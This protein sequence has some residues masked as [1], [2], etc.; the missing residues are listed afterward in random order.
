MARGS[1][2]EPVEVNPASAIRAERVAITRA[3]PAP[4]RFPHFHDAAE[5]IWFAEVDGSLD[6]ED[7]TFVLGSGTA[8]FLPP[9]RRHD[10]AI[11]SGDHR[12][13]LVHLDPFLTA[14]LLERAAGPAAATCRVVRCEGALRERMAMLFDWLTEAAATDAPRAIVTGI[15]GLILTALILADA[16]AAPEPGDTIGAADRLRPAL[17]RIA[18]NPGQPITLGE[19]ASACHLS[20]AYFS[21][22]FKQVFGSTFSDYLRAYRLRLAAQRLLSGGERV[23]EIA[24]ATGFASPAHMTEQFRRR[25]GVTPRAYRAGAR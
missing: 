16:P 17:D 20:E 4:E 24:R 18:R 25:F 9:M 23:S 5:L 8:V 11:P 13:V 1:I 19:A 7:G 2:C 22:R 6:S 21:R 3:D 12:W 14:S 10:F 15:A